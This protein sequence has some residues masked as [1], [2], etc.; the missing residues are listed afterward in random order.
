MGKIILASSSPRRAEILRNLGISFSIVPSEYKE[1]VIKKPPNELVCH[2][3]RNKAID[4]KKRCL[5]DDIIIAADTIVCMNERII[6]KPKSKQDAFQ[7]L[8][9]LN[10]K[11]HQVI[12]GLCILCDKYVLNYEGFE[13]T[14]VFFKHLSDEEIWD[15]IDTCEPMDKAGAYG[16]Q[17]IG[18]VFVEK[19]DGCYYN[20]VGLPIKKVYSVLREMGI[21]LIKKGVDYEG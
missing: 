3:A 15:Y 17:G 20:V 14:N 11:E 19:I 12:T 1:E 18:G 7:I 16:I 4:V 5:Y 8:K 13:I 9:S 10:G 21:N 6:G 2:L